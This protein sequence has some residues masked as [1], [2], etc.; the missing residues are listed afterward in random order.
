MEKR[1]LKGNFIMLSYPT[2]KSILLADLNNPE[3]VERPIFQPISQLIDEHWQHTLN[4]ALNRTD[5]NFAIHDYIKCL[6]IITRKDK[7]RIFYCANFMSRPRCCPQIKPSIY[8]IH[9]Y[10]V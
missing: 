1:N 6:E 9:I 10:I 2:S 4:D 7:R 5:E 3:E 8:L